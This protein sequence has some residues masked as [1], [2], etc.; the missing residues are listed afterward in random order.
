MKFSIENNQKAWIFAVLAA[1]IVS[2]TFLNAYPIS[3]L[4]EAK[5]AEAAREMWVS[6]N[7]W[8]PTFNG[9]LRTDKPPLHYYFMLFGFKLF[10]TTVLGA[11]FFSAVMGF[12]MLLATFGFARRHLGKDVAQT[13]LLIL[14]GSFFFMQEFHLAVPDPYLIAFVTL[15][16]FSF[17]HF[18]ETKKSLYLVLFYFFLGLGVLSKGPVAIALPGL[19][20]G[21]FLVLQKELKNTFRY[22]PVLGLLGIALLVVPWFWQVHLKTNGLWT[23]GFFFDH[24]INRFSAPM[25]GHGGSFLVT[26]GFVLLGL[27]PF[28]FFIPQ[29]FRHAWHKRTNPVL[30]FASCVAAVFIL[31][32]SISSTKLPNYTMPGYAFLAFLLGAFFTKK[33]EVGFSRWDIISVVLLTLLGLALPVAAYIGM[34]QEATLVSLSYLAFG[35]APTAIG[36]LMGFVFYFRKKITAFLLTTAFSWGILLF[37]LHGYLYPNLTPVL[38]TTAVA[39]VLPKDTSIV[40]YKRMD[41]AFPFNYQ[42]TF[43]VIDNINDATN[44]HGFYLLTNH[45]EGQD[46]GQLPNIELVIRRKALFENHTTVLYRIK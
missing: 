44:L 27:L 3:I 45:P 22:Y 39:E 24:N 26:W 1:A 28:S 8:V 32:F 10:G 43:E 23:Q 7:Y 36:T 34:Q 33:I 14:V 41:A 13:T 31:F 38:P 20:V 17:Y 16:L 11:R 29:A 35:L 12:V 46:L 5:N 15:G 19:S 21:L 40:V 42:Q 6:G 9:E 18:Y 25:E 4:D 37:I 30:V 2:F